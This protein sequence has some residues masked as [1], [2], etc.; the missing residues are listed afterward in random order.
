MLKRQ[1]STVIVQ[2]ALA[3][4]DYIEKAPGPFAGKKLTMPRG[5]ELNEGVISDPD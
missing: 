2:N 4:A 1:E 3:L 5:D